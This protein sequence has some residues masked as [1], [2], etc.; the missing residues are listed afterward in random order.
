MEIV[1]LLEIIPLNYSAAVFK[2]ANFTVIKKLINSHI[3]SQNM[4]LEIS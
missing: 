2:F 4:E 3:Q 1:L